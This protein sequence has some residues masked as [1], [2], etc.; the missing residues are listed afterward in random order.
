MAR[1]IL[2]KKNV[3]F[4]D[5]DSEVLAYIE[6]IATSTRN[7]FQSVVVNILEEHMRISQNKAIQGHIQQT[8][9]TVAIELPTVEE[10]KQLEDTKQ[11]QQT[12]RDNSSTINAMLKMKKDS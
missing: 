7:S 11:L 3:T 2:A 9:N 6:N 1:T 4:F 12:F 10:H 8:T 5:T